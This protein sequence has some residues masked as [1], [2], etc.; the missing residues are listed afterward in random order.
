MLEGNE[1]IMFIFGYN[2]YIYL[3]FYFPSKLTILA[4]ALYGSKNVSI[5]MFGL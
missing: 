3:Y 2:V 5:L 4:W 1:V